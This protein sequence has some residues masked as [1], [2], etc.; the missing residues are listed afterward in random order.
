MKNLLTLIICLSFTLNYSQSERL[1]EHEISF[2]VNKKQK[3][4]KS[5][6]LYII[7]ENDTLKGKKINDKYYFPYIEKEF[8][9]V[10]KIN[11]IQ[12]KAGPF[13]PT[14]LNSDCD[15]DLGIINN[16]KKMTSVAEYNGMSE[17]DKGWE[18]YS[19]RYYIVNDIYTIDI[20][21]PKKVR[22]L[23]YLVLNG[24]SNSSETRLKTNIVVQKITKIKNAS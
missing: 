21:N 8:S 19:K 24:K 2:N 15:L 7:I 20:E 6:Y 9:I 16:I 11:K 5:S 13:Q 17:S 1:S 14:V 4:I 3:E 23:Q 18:W 22:E 10:L 12:F